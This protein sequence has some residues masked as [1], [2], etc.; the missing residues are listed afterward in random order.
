M[1]S[2]EF[3]VQYKF[4]WYSLVTWASNQR[5]IM[6]AQKMMWHWSL[7][8]WLLKIQLY[9]HRNK[10]HFKIYVKKTMAFKIVIIVH[11]ITVFLIKYMQP[12]WDFW[13]DI[14]NA[15]ITDPKLWKSVCLDIFFKLMAFTFYS[16]L[17]K[18]SPDFSDSHTELK[19]LRL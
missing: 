1:L 14:K 18:C 10:W 7:K 8:Q 3:Y 15:Y 19:L 13:W 16:G 17:P 11:N 6:I 5:I 4:T 9:H 12:W 2:L